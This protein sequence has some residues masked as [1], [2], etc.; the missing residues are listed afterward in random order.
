MRRI[1]NFQ[2]RE[3]YGLRPDETFPASD[4]ARR[5]FAPGCAKALRAGDQK[6]ILSLSKGVL[7]DRSSHSREYMAVDQSATLRYLMIEAVDKFLTGQKKGSK[8]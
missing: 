2:Q 4:R 6:S 3:R 5:R 7:G 8:T 1:S